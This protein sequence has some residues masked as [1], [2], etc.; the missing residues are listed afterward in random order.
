MNSASLGSLAPLRKKTL[1]HLSQEPTM[2]AMKEYYLEQSIRMV[3]SDCLF[4]LTGQTREKI[5]LLSL[6][7][8][9]KSYIYIYVIDVPC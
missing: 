4:T 1:N 6:Q 3:Y 5:I 9:L 8:I 7:S 2:R